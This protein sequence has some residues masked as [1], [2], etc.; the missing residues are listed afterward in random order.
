[1]MEPASS[2]I[3]WEKL[4]SKKGAVGHDCAGE[5]GQILFAKK[6]QRNL[7]QPFGQCNTPH[8]AFSIGG[9]VGGIV[10]E[11]SGEQN[12]TDAHRHSQSYKTR[13]SRREHRRLADR[14]LRKNNSPTGNIKE[15]FCSTQARQPLTRSFA[16]CSERAYRFWSH[17]IIL[18]YLLC[19]FP[20]NGS[21]IVLPHP[22]EDRLLAASSSRLVPL[23]AICPS[24]MT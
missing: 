9:K 2:G 17:F 18:L 7:P 23:S 24:Q 4:C 10:L 8:A 11:V 19:N 14:S 5:I 16:P 1:M 15:R 13:F 3:K 21:L 20:L 12:Q 22:A 6:G